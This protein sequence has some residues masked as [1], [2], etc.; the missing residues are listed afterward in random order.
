MFAVHNRKHLAGVGLLLALLLTAG[1]VSAEQ[2]AVDRIV[3]FGASLSD[4]GNA[5]AW[6]S[7]PGNGSCGTRLNVPPYAALDDLAIPDGPYARGGHHFTN[8]DTWVEGLAR[9]LALAG[10]ARPALRNVGTQAS[11]YAMGGA[12]AVANYPCR[13][14]LPAQIDA[15]LADFP[16]TSPYSLVTIEIGGNDVRDALSAGAAGQNPAPYIGNALASLGEGIFRLYAHGA[17]RFLVLD[18]ADVGKTPAVRALDHVFPGIALAAGALSNAYNAG[19]LQLLQGLAGLP[20]IDLRVLDIHATLDDVVATP[21]E[22]GFVNAVDACITPE[23][24]PFQCA[25]PSDYL[26]WDGIHPTAALHA[27]VA[28]EALA[29]ISTP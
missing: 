23:V 7:D 25:R 13:F 18:V 19:L 24:P 3:V 4:S 29:V 14:N 27:I 22:F 28:Q 16:Q 21:G 2:T 26:F 1:A 9:H 10:N 15:Y 20:D 5:F 11:N 17:R 12:R 6:L 8:G